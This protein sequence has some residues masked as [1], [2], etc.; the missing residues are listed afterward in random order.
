[1][2][3]RIWI[4]ESNASQTIGMALLACHRERV[5]LMTSTASRA[6]IHAS[7][8]TSYLSDDLEEARDLLV[9]WMA[10]AD[11]V[12]KIVRRRE[13]LRPV[14]AYIGPKTAASSIALAVMFRDGRRI[15]EAWTE[16]AR[17]S[18]PRAYRIARI[19]NHLQSKSHG[20]GWDR[21]ASWLLA[22]VVIAAEVQ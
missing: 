6:T 1:M 7:L 11:A 9:D 2:S 4:N 22:N 5:E 3:K 18:C 12:D 15:R 19:A 13:P 17:D 10:V 16:A 14:S 8:Q 21:V 20:V